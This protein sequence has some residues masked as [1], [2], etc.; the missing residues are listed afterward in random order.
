MGG[1]AGAWA[2]AALA[3][4][5]VLL[6]GCAG[7]AEEPTRTPSA[8]DD[9]DVQPTVEGKGAVAGLVVDDAIRPVVGA[10]IAIAG[11][12]AATTDETGVFVLDA[13]EPGLVIFSVSA[14]GFL[15]VQTSADV[16]PGQTAE[17]RVQLPRDDSPEPYLVTYS[18][19]GFMQV[20]GGI[21]QFVVEGI[22]EGS[23]LC[24]CRIYFTPESN[25]STI[26]F[27]AYWEFTM[28]DPGGLAE[29]YWVVEQPEGEGYEADYCFS[30]CVVHLDVEG[31]SFSDGV[32]TYA[33]IDG[34]DFWVA[35]QQQVQL[36]VTVWHNGA[37]P[38]GWTLAS[39]GS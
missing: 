8:L 11:E 5:A 26:V 34:P 20:W 9:V 16:A 2:I 1:V 29:F 19:N 14:D 21:G 3:S 30:P 12:E 35:L 36:F 38:D 27:E 22:G 13:L 25:A 23:G 17:V 31:A 10:S 24:D 6:A 15:P 4:A 33:R 32:E 7:G 39:E 18:H 28:P 37:A